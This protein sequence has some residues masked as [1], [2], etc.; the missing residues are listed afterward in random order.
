MCMDHHMYAMCNGYARFT[1][2]DL[3]IPE[4]I[5]LSELNQNTHNTISAA[6]SI[7]EYGL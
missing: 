1:C 2:E 5:K 7:T 6:T 3:G 4:L